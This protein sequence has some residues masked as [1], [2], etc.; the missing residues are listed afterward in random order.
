MKVLLIG[1][2]PDPVNGVSVAN[3]NLKKYL[4]DKGLK[5]SHINTNFRNI[6]S[7]QGE[8]LPLLQVGYF[9]RYY[10]Q[11]FKVIFTN[12]VYIT[13]GQTFFGVVKYAPFILTSLL[14]R[15]P[16]IIHI[17]GNHFG[18]EFENLHG[19]KKRVFAFLVSKAGMG[20]VLSQSLTKNFNGLLPV[21]K[22]RMVENFAEDVFFLSADPGKKYDK[23]RILY[24]SNLIKEKGILDVLQSLI[25]LKEKGIPFQAE[26]AGSIEKSIEKEFYEKILSLRDH[27]IYHKE[28]KGEVKKELLLNANVFILPTYYSMEG[29][30]ISIL[31]AM[32]SGNAVIC[33][34]L[35][36]IT[37][38]INERNA[39]FVERQN[40][41]QIAEKLEYLAI[42]LPQLKE[43]G[44]YNAAFAKEKFRLDI[45]GEK[46]YQILKEACRT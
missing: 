15:K 7:K 23:L 37:D 34:G 26:I 24:I 3:I 43:Y 28:A 11:A 33:T 30:P 21:H 35:P 8:G 20:I 13:P 2:F 17:H 41:T 40:P 38:I 1:P 27:V 19:I 9:I 39:I 14:F 22:I 25:L 42:N 12:V 5:V 44:E 29:Q 31:E 45:F 4:L 18:K 36:G 6:S 46:I 32:A 10:L 16:Y